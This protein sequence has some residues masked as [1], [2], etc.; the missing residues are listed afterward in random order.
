MEQS[1]LQECKKH[2]LEIKANLEKELASV[3]EPDTGDHEIGD[4][5]AKFPDFGAENYLDGGSDSPDEVE[6]YEVNLSVTSQ[7]ESYLHKV[8]AALERIEQ[9]TYGVDIH[10][11]KPISIERLRANPAAETAITPK[12]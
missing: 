12:K 11:G 5:R 1:E 8:T 2:L 6:A 7:L 10:T 9:G 4:Y 3:S